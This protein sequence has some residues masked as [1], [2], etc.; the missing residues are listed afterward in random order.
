MTGNGKEMADIFQ[1]EKYRSQMLKLIYHPRFNLSYCKILVRWFQIFMKWSEKAFG[2]HTA[3][4]LPVLCI[5]HVIFIRSKGQRQGWNFESVWQPLSCA[6]SFSTGTF[7]AQSTFVSS[8][9]LMVLFA[10]SLKLTLGNHSLPVL[11]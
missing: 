5:F 9:S 4:H 11:F 1:M 2:L 3:A 8:A 10:L 7:S 6:S